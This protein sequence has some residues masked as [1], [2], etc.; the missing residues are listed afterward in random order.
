MSP[1]F[2]KTWQTREDR[3]GV[4]WRFLGI[5]VYGKTFLPWETPTDLPWRLPR[6]AVNLFRAQEQEEVT[7]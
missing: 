3:I 4:V 7:L 6:E 5:P 2:Y 1:I